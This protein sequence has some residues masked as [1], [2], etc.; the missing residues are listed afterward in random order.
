MV[1]INSI[2][3]HLIRREGRIAKL[4]AP[5][6]D[7]ATVSARELFVGNP[8]RINPV[9]KI[10]PDFTCVKAHAKPAKKMNGKIPLIFRLFH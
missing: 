8:D 3:C 1:I 2:L 10:H 9:F 5:H 7:F 4:S 6:P